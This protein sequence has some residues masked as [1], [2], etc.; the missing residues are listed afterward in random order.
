MLER[1]S[2]IDKVDIRYD[3]EQASIVINNR[4]LRF[5]PT[6]YK[7]I[8]L[9]L[10]HTMVQE[11]LLFE[12]VSLN[13]TDANA[14]KLLTKYINKIRNKIAASDFLLLLEGLGRILRQD[15]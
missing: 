6:E 4:V 15:K 11:T 12:A 10:L 8:R 1:C 13:V 9:F 2:V 3:D 14:Q 5:S 7:L